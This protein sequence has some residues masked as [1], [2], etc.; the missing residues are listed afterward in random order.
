MNK[1]TKVSSFCRLRDSKKAIELSINFLVIII[2]AVVVFSIGIYLLNSLI[3]KAGGLQN[4]IDEDLDKQIELTHCPTKVCIP[5]NF[6]KIQKEKIEVF[7]LIIFNDVGERTKFKIDIEQSFPATPLL[8][9][10]PKTRTIELDNNDDARVGIGIM[11][12][13]NSTKEIYIFN[14]NVTDITH[15]KHYG[16]QQIRVE[17]V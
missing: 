13:R 11:A 12:Y 6:K 8:D 9:W 7:G 10:R 2:L 1:T 15:G 16:L 4:I 5:V 3:S 17:V 14:V